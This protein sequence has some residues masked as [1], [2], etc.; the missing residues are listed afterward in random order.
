MKATI[1]ILRGLKEKYEVHHGVELPTRRSSPPPKL[2]H[3]YIIDRFLPDKAIDL[4]D[5]AASRLRIEID[6]LPQEIDKV[7]R[8]I[9][10]L[11]IQRQALLKEKDKAGKERLAAGSSTR[12]RSCV[13]SSAGMKAQWQS[14]KKAIHD[15][16]QIKAEI[17]ALPQRGRSG[18]QPGRPAESRRAALRPHPRA[19]AQG[20][21]EE[22]TAA[23]PGDP[24]A[25][26]KYL[27][28]EV[29]AEDIAEIVAD[30]PASR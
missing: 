16:Q 20:V 12:S 14:E 27:K 7:E 17:D 5:E 29:D 9:I 10:Q 13:S 28:E 19:G 8:R 26:A 22:E 15:L 23:A 3:R 21:G 2:S 18:H 4:V 30:G 24:A 6:S 25:K 11:E 1:A